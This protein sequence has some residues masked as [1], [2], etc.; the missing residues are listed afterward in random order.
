VH[1]L[2]SA[3]AHHMQVYDII[4]AGERLLARW[5]HSHSSIPV[6]LCVV[7]PGVRLVGRGM[8]H[9]MIVSVQ[10][11]GITISMLS[12]LFATW[13]VATALISSQKHRALGMPDLLRACVSIR[14]P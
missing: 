3:T 5:Q 11:C 13:D 9:Q 4:Q 1:E 8:L 12:E 7:C 14:V 10:I 2:V 6:C